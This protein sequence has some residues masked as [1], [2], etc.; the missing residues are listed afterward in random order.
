MTSQD[1]VPLTEKQRIKDTQLSTKLSSTRLKSMKLSTKTINLLDGREKSINY[2]AQISLP[3][4]VAFVAVSEGESLP[5]N[6]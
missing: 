2:L 3:C 5:M 1:Y 4:D 6:T